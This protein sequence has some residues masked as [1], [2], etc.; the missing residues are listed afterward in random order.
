MAKRTDTRMDDRDP[1]Q[2]EPNII[3]VPAEKPVT[4][5][6]IIVAC[7]GGFETRTGCEG[8]HTAH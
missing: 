1:N 8:F 7:G 4:D 6:C 2:I 5:G 3:F